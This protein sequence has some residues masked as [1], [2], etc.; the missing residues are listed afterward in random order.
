M[1]VIRNFG[2]SL[3]IVLKQSTGKEFDLCERH[4][5]QS[6]THRYVSRQ[7]LQLPVTLTL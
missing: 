1:N 2:P 6:S 4:E 3:G 7:N 5:P